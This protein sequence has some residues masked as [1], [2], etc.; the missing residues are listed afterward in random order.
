MCERERGVCVCACER[1]RV[2]VCMCVCIMLCLCV[3]NPEQ[4]VAVCWVIQLQRVC[5]YI[6]VH[7]AGNRSSPQAITLRCAPVTFNVMWSLLEKGLIG[8]NT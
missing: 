5:M 7:Q 6:L 2:C 4:M 8:S 3:C 1:E